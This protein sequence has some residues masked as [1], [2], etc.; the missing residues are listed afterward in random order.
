MSGPAMGS[1]ADE[2]RKICPFVNEASKATNQ[3]AAAVALVNTM[4][5]VSDVPP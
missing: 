4:W 2:D 1:M 3:G 5:R